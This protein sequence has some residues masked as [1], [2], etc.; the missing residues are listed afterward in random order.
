M[1]D[2]V[3]GPD[4]QDFSDVRVDVHGLTGAPR[5]ELTWLDAWG[6]PAHVS[7]EALRGLIPAERFNCGFLIV[8]TPEWIVITQGFIDK[9]FEGKRFV[10]GFQL[11]PRGM[12]KELRVVDGK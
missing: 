1:P 9:L 4:G 3:I 11:I 7:E 8:E 2:D 5:V 10:D 6:D 12:I